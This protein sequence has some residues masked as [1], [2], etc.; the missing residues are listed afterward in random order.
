LDVAHADKGVFITTSDFND[1]ALEAS[2][3]SS[4]KIVT[5]NGNRLA[6][7]MIEHD[8]GVSR[9]DEFI[10]KRLDIDYFID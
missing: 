3:K 7:L 10:I 2:Q 8:I 6:K 9:E 1:D 4:K 5:I